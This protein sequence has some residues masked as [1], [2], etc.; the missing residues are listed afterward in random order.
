LSETAID[1]PAGFEYLPRAP[2]INHV[3]PIYQ[4]IDN[5]P[6]AIL[7]GLRVALVHANTMG[8]MHGGM[9]ATLA[10]SAMARSSVNFLKRRMVTLKMTME[11]LDAIRVGDWLEIDGR[12]AEHDTDF[13]HTTCELRVGGK[14]RVKASGLFRLLK[15]V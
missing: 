14:A 11:Y 5:A 2:F 12:L 9:A 4:A 6:G 13:A 15:A 8:L 3:G 1:P 10:D 7:L